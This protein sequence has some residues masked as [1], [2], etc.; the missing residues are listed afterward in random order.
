MDADHHRVHPAMERV[1]DVARASRPPGTTGPGD[2]LAA[3]EELEA[4]LYPHLR[5]EE[6]EAMPLVAASITAADWHAWDQE[7]NI[8]GLSFGELALTGLWTLDGQDPVSHALMSQVV[9]R[10]VL[11]RHHHGLRPALPPQDRPPVGRHPSSHCRRPDQG[12]GGLAMSRVQR[13]GTVQADVPAT[14]AQVWQV[15][16]DVPRIGEWSHECHTAQWLDGADR[17]AVAARFRG[18]NKA[19]FARWSRPCTI[20]VLDADRCF[21]YRTNGGVMRD[22]TEWA[23]TLEPTDSGG[24]ITQS[25]EIISLPRATEW[26]ISKVLPEHVDRSR[27]LREDLARLGAVAETVPALDTPEPLREPPHVPG[28]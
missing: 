23:F 28:T 3:I 20:V 11:F 9:P 12:H 2:L 25:Y 17:A 15:L 26:V 13:T 8:K 7:H 19:R 5:G 22:A 21:T 1:A 16:T 6:E 10:P 4:V 24:R 14:P 18:T 27:A